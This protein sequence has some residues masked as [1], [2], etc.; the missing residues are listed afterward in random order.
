MEKAGSQELTAAARPHFCGSGSREKEMPV[1]NLLLF[2]FAFYLARDPCPWD[3]ATHIQGGPSLLYGN[4]LT[5][6][7]KGTLTTALGIFQF[8]K[9]DHKN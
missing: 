7:L 2:I 8:N 1:L 9:S 5:D 4:V 6:T 3:V